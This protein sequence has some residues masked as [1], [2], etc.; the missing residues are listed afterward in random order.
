MVDVPLLLGSCLHG[1][2]GI[3]YQPLVLLLNGSW[4]SY[5]LSTDC[6]ENTSSTVLP[7]LHDI[8]IR[9]DCI[10]N[11]ASHNSFIVAY[12]IVV[13]MRVVYCAIT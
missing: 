10:E 5:V 2:L 12:A 13:L 7:L 3:S 8:A 9:M 6:T 4:F 11:T 1:L